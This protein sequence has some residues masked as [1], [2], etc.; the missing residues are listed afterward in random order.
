MTEGAQRVN[1]AVQ[2]ATGSSAESS[3]FTIIAQFIKDNLSNSRGA[4]TVSEILE[5]LPKE[6]A[7]LQAE[8]RQF[9]GC[10]NLSSKLSFKYD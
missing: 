3:D 1:N 5:Y 7:S 4:F 8:C 2:Q 6:K 9:L 10:S